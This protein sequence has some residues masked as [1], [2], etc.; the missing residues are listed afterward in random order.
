MLVGA[1]GS[2]KKEQKFLT[3]FEVGWHPSSKGATKRRY[4]SVS[5]NFHVLLPIMCHY[6][7]DSSGS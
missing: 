1:C 2:Y 7:E 5:R 6:V 4:A 3:M